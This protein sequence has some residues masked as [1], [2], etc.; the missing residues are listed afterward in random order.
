[1]GSGEDAQRENRLGIRILKETLRLLYR[2]F[3]PANDQFH[4]LEGLT[5]NGFFSL[6]WDL[7]RDRLEMNET[8]TLLMTYF[9]PLLGLV[10]KGTGGVPSL[11]GGQ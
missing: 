11:E 5:K 1:M 4:S 7:C 9:Y 2:H 10:E 8:A 6:E 3:S